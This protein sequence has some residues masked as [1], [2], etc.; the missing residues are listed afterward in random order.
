LVGK[1][2]VDSQ[3]R[4]R[5]GAIASAAVSVFLVSQLKFSVASVA[6]AS[7]DMWAVDFMV[8]TV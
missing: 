6:K 2:S 8:G 5:V 1:E 7:R 4:L 3:R